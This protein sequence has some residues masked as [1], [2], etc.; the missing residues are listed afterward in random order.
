LYD[1]AY[2]YR[3]IKLRQVRC[4]SGFYDEHARLAERVLLRDVKAACDH[5]A[6]HLHMTLELVFP[7]DGRTARDR[8][9]TRAAA[10]PL[11]IGRVKRWF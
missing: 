2:R 6:R 4:P 9:S 7:D 8:P 1:Q 11:S 10:G 3:R 5:L